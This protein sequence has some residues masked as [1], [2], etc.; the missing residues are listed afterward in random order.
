VWRWASRGLDTRFLLDRAQHISGTR[1]V[2]Q[3]D[4][5]LDLVF[6]TRGARRSRGGRR[7]LG[8][9]AEVVPDQNGFVFFQRAGV[10]FLFGNTDFGEH[11]K[12]RLALDL[13]LPRQIIDS[14]LTHPPSRLLPTGSG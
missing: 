13:Q 4:F 1:D 5:G 2:R 14:N 3:I 12:N 6:A 10:R 8:M 11:V 7:F 9:S